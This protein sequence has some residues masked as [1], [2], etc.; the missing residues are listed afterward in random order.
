MGKESRAL[1]LSRKFSTVVRPLETHLPYP[2]NTAGRLGKSPVGIKVC[3]EVYRTGELGSDV[4]EV[5]VGLPTWHDSVG[6][7]LPRGV[8]VMKNR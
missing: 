2:L 1:L 4:P 6:D 7:V 8:L 3:E 5:P